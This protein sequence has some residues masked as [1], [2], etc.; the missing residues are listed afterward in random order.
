MH[1]VD[2]PEPEDRLQVTTE[3]HGLLVRVDD[4]VAVSG[5]EGHRPCEEE[6]VQE[7]LG[8][9]GPDPDRPEPRKPRNADHPDAGNVDVVSL[10]VRQQIDARSQLGRDERAVVHAER[11]ASRREEGLGRDDE[12]S[13]AAGPP[14][15]FLRLII[16]WSRRNRSGRARRPKMR[17]CAVAA[18]RTRLNPSAGRC[19]SS[20]AGSTNP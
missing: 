20:P 8:P 2:Q 10:T 6:D 14:T 18:R 3:E 9:R 4:V 5:E 15:Y 13:H 19:G 1:V 11:R 7:E 12:D 16:V 17:G